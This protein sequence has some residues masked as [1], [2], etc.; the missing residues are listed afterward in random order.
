MQSESTRRLRFPSP[1]SDPCLPSTRENEQ[2]GYSQ[3][4]SAQQVG[5]SITMMPGAGGGRDLATV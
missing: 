1:L 4:Q 3:Q 5:F 2:V